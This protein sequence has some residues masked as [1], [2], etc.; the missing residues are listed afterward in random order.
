M[1]LIPL[2]HILSLLR[3]SG[4]HFIPHCWCWTP[5]AKHVSK[6]PLRIQHRQVCDIFPD[7]SHTCAFPLVD[8]TTSGAFM[9]E[10]LPYKEPHCTVS[11]GSVHYGR[12]DA[13]E[14]EL[15][16][17]PSQDEFDGF[18]SKALASIRVGNDNPD[19]CFPCYG[20]RR[21]GGDIYETD[22][23]VV[24]GAFTGVYEDTG[25]VDDISCHDLFIRTLCLV[26]ILFHNDS[27]EQAFPR[28]DAK[29]WYGRF[30]G[31]HCGFL[32]LVPEIL[33]TVVTLVVIEV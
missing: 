29:V 20:L 28:E 23:L 25:L 6:R 13:V 26:G 4:E 11:H 24:M 19:I 7:T 17:H 22:W 33:D 32:E 18:A 12:L 27:A 9:F 8:G 5:I 14:V 3:V 21:S 16:E 10:T 31:L 2:H 1:L 15:F 30:H